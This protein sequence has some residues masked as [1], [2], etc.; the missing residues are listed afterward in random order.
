MPLLPPLAV[1]HSALRP[2]LDVLHLLRINQQHPKA[3]CLQSCKEGI[4]EPPS[5]FEATVIMLQV[6]SWSA[7]AFRSAVQ[8]SA[9]RTGEE[10]SLGGNAG[11]AF[12][13]REEWS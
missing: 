2:P 10:S 13:A 11:A 8:A 4:Q 1:M 3:A 5:R 9:Q 6:S 12:T 7:K